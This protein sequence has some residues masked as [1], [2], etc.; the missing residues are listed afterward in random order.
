MSLAQRHR[1]YR[2]F[3]WILLVYTIAVILWGT[4]VRASL[5]GDGCGEHWPLCNGQVLPVEAALKTWIELTHRVTSGI[6]WIASLVLLLWARRVWPAPHPTRRYAAWAFVFMCTESLVGAALV[7]LRLVADNPDFARAYWMGAHL[8]N[9]FLLLSA[10]AFAALTASGAR[11][12]RLRGHPFGALLATAGLAILLVGMTGAV[13]ALGDTVFR[14]TT[15]SSFGEKIDHAQQALGQLGARAGQEESHATDTHIFV[16]LRVIHPLLALATAAFMLFMSGSILGR[17]SDRVL[18]QLAMGIS[19]LVL[20]QV[21]IGFLN[22]A[23]LAPVWLQLV[24]LFVA[25]A[26]WISLMALWAWS[27]PEERMAPP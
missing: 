25:D 3:S 21:G 27:G 6:A 5:S 15:E 12:W 23:W 24:H 18:R 2:R 9:T 14:P 11:P 1:A 17:V 22:V 4:F 20:V 8:I 13:T 10:L 26:I 19:A 7:L 16:Q